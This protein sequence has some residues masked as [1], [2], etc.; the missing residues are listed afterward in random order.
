MAE[1]ETEASPRTLEQILEGHRFRCNACGGLTR[2]DV[3]RTVRFKMFH[4]QDIAGSPHF[5]E[6]EVVSDT[7]D[8]VH[9]RYCG[10]GKS[11]VEIDEEGNEVTPS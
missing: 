11:V 6:L 7:I 2:F 4:H 3:V 5:E 8:E 1:A 10:N 9:C